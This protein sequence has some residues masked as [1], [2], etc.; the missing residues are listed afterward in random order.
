M[1][2]EEKTF[3]VT[4]MLNYSSNRGV[5]N[6]DHTFSKKEVLP[7]AVLYSI[8]EGERLTEVRAPHYIKK[9]APSCVMKSCTYRVAVRLAG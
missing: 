3:S 5:G 4:K 6:A 7:D 2:G 9:P 8:W 1:S